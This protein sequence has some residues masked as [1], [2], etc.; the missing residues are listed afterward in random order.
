MLTSYATSREDSTQLFKRIQLLERRSPSFRRDTTLVHAYLEATHY[1]LRQDF[2]YVETYAQKAWDLAQES[3][4]DK[5]KILAYNVLGY[6]YVESNDYD[7]LMEL[8]TESYLLSEK[9]KL[10]VYKAHAAR[11]IGNSYAEHKRWDSSRVYYQEA[12]T[13]YK[14]LDNDSLV[15]MGYTDLGNLFRE[16]DQLAPALK[17]YREAYSLFEKIGSEY[18]I[19]SVLMNEGFLLVKA[20]KIPKALS[21]FYRALAIYQKL[22]DRCGKMS[23]YNDIS[24]AYNYINESEKAII[25][26]KEALAN[27]RQ[28][29]SVK[30]TNWALLSMYSAYKAM[31]RTADA[32]AV[33]E[34]VDR[35]KR[36]L[37]EK[38]IERRATIHQLL[39]DNHLKDIE[40]QKAIIEQQEATQKF[41]IG[42]S[43]LILLVVGL[44]WWNNNKL[45]EKN[46]EIRE[47]LVKG[48]T[49]ERKRVAAELHDNL[50]SSI[51][52]INWYLHGLD[53]K[54]L[55]VAEK[56][57][58]ERIKEMV[59]NAYDEVRS[60]SHNLLPKELEKDGLRVALH[61]LKQKLNSNGR[62]V[63][64]LEMD[65]FD[66]RLDSKTEFELYSMILELANNII[67]H[68]DATQATISLHNNEEQIALC[69]E[70]NGKGMGSIGTEG[71][72][73]RNV[74]SRVDSLRGKI[75]IVDERVP[76]TCVQVQIP[77]GIAA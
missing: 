3:N 15:A 63:F 22:D 67:K 24:N 73:L 5:G 47:A 21:N 68:S 33:L 69:V 23:A 55:S 41:L 56:D 54:S 36:V 27:A 18:G 52:T 20:K 66:E 10:P 26:G 64:F 75:R 2:S 1:Y 28:Y 19:A 48:Q 51:S 70:D 42:F 58:Y 13:I 37:R 6:A 61:K 53:S 14:S 31:G 72:G 7:I 39:F 4:W 38:S 8:A 40:I 60:L 50:G 29:H 35:S 71:A 76:G 62:I 30:Q 45:R 11:F 65:G 44:L 16:N 17:Y 57:T 49:L 34:K 43:I 46:A 25:A 12:I 59:G 9:L 77:K 32:L 74:R